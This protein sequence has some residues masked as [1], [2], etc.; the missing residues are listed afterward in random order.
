MIEEVTMSDEEEFN[1]GKF[2]FLFPV[3]VESRVSRLMLKLQDIKG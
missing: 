2:H 3:F 1:I